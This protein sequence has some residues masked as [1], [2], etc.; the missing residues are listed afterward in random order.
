MFTK[1]D[2][3]RA[4]CAYVHTCGSPSSRPLAVAEACRRAGQKGRR[5]LIVESRDD[6]YTSLKTLL[7]RAGQRVQRA[8]TGAAVAATVVRFAPDLVLVNEQMPDE[9]GWLITCKLRIARA[10]RTVWLYAAR[11]PRLLAERMEISA[12]DQVIVYGGVLVRLRHE[13]F[14][15][16]LEWLDVSGNRSLPSY[17]ARSA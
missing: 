11:G 2:R 10:Q 5:V 16:F 14:R 4:F 7:E 12:V 15:R 8:R 1:Q 6:V 3:L 13:I 17:Q 9:S